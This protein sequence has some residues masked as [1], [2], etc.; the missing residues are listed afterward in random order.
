MMNIQHF[1]ARFLQRKKVQIESI[2]D[3][4]AQQLEN[5]VQANS[6]TSEECAAASLKMSGQG[7]HLEGLI[8]KFRVGSFS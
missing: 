4:T 3:E 1:V 5:V 8:R 7:E 6:A 2:P